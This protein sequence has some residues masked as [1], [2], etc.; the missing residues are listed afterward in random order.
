M[1]NGVQEEEPACS[2]M[3]ERV[4]YLETPWFTLVG[5]QAVRQ[6][7]SAGTT[8]WKGLCSAQERGLSKE[9]E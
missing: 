1:R 2:R 6:E 8:P 5:E 7:R 4:K 3:Q 9:G